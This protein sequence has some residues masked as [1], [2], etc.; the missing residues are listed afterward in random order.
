MSLG[1]E[2]IISILAARLIAYWKTHVSVSRKEWLMKFELTLNYYLAKASLIFR[3]A[4]M[5]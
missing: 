2:N 5:I 1:S 3:D 4:C